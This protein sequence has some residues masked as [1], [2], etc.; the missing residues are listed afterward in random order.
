M[1]TTNSLSALIFGRETGPKSST[2]SP[3]FAKM[4]MHLPLLEMSK[5]TH[6]VSTGLSGA[7]GKTMMED[8]GIGKCNIKGHICFKKLSSDL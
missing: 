3:T 5:V 2:G 4:V 6:G 8:H 1:I 7:N